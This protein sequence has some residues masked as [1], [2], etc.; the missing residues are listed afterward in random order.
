VRLNNR[1]S[2][3]IKSITSYP[4]FHV[5]QFEPQGFVVTAAH[6]DARYFRL[7]RSIGPAYDRPGR[8]N[9]RPSTL[10][11]Q[12]NAGANLTSGSDIAAAMSSPRSAG[13]TELSTRTIHAPTLRRCFAAQDGAAAPSLPKISL[14]CAG[15]GRIPLFRL[16][17]W[18]L[19][20]GCSALQDSQRLLTSSATVMDDFTILLQFF[21]PGLTRE[22]RCQGSLGA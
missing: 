1:F 6:D 8:S 7:S 18:M 3:K 16:G 19:V 9:V 2:G 17:H 12:P 21:C 20:V 5:I 4:H 15:G 22:R 14:L 13:G 10:R 11:T